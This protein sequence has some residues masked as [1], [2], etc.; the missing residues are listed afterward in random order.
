MLIIYFGW[1]LFW[2]NVA[3]HKNEKPEK[4]LH[5]LA[6]IAIGFFFLGMAYLELKKNFYIQ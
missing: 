2:M 3:A 5:T 6:Y 4:F 1:G